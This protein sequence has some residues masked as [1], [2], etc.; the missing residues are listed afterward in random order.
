M[1]KNKRSTEKCRYFIIND[2]DVDDNLNRRIR[3]IEDGIMENEKKYS[4]SS[5]DVK[6]LPSLNKDKVNLRAEV[7]LQTKIFMSDK[8]T[9]KLNDTFNVIP[10]DLEILTEFCPFD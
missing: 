4:L 7:C 10:L 1:R 5:V 2:I 9:K 8:D 6:I 3:C